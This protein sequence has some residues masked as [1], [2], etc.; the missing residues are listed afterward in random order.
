MAL[1]GRFLKQRER[2]VLN[3][4]SYLFIS[5]LFAVFLL[6]RE[7]AVCAL[8][9]AILGDTGAAL[10][11]MRFGRHRL[12][13]KSLEGTFACLCICFAIALLIPHLPLLSRLLGPVVATLTELLPKGLDDNL[14]VPIVGGGLMEILG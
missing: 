3:A 9:F 10:V 5:S 11:G 13:G 8:S 4:G 1:F 6:R 2:K 12:W 14:V 7:I